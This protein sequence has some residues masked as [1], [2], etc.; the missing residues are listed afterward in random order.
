VSHPHELHDGRW[1]R[2]LAESSGFEFVMSIVI[3]FSAVFIFVQ[4]DWVSQN[5]EED[6][7]YAFHIVETTFTVIFS[8]ELVLRLASLGLKDF[9]FGPDR[10]WNYI[11]LVVVLMALME[12]VVTSH[13]HNIV[14]RNVAV[15]RLLRILRIVRVTRI[16]RALKI[17][18]NL[19]LM[20]Q[21][22][23]GCGNSLFWAIVL[24]LTIILVFAT[25]FTQVVTASLAENKGMFTPQEEKVLRTS[26]GSLLRTVYSLFK[27]IAGGVS[28]GELAD[29]L[30]NMSPAL[31]VIFCLFIVF[32]VFAVMN[33]ITGIFVENACKDR[34]HDDEM[35]RNCGKRPLY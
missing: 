6:I 18:T 2:R 8:A 29:P 26:Y 30:L 11:D 27:A 10:G 20:V 5:G 7:P 9:F 1:A 16:L 34:E 31:C 28:W 3:I 14:N 33:I 4:T 24:L 13:S 22:I 21:G 23:I 12:T 19:R 25:C 15:L 35:K 32:V 17:F